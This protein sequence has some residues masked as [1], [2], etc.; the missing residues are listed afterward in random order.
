MDHRQHADCSA[1]VRTVHDEV[2]RPDVMPVLQATTHTG[3][4]IQLQATPYQLFLWHFQP[5]ATPVA[6]HALVIEVPALM[7]GQR[8]DSPIVRMTL[9][10]CPINNGVSQG[11]F[12]I[13][14]HVDDPLGLEVP[15]L[16]VRI[17]WFH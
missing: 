11:V 8:G 3:T 10:A 5:L 2:V 7:I 15:F 16:N 14:Q 13:A 17:P 9:F 1:V 12:V 6:P 4:F